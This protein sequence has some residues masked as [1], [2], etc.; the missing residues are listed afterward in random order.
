MLLAQIALATFPT[1]EAGMQYPRHLGRV[2]TNIY[3][4]YSFMCKKQGENVDRECVIFSVFSFSPKK[5]RERK[6]SL[7]LSV[8]DRERKC[9]GDERN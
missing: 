9:V 1:F 3:Q 7:G 2:P 6:N 4:S 8:F 5:E